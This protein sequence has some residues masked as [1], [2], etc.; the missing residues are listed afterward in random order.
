MKRRSPRLPE[1]T[2][3]VCGMLLALL[4]PIHMLLTGM[5]FTVSDPDS[6]LTLRICL[7]IVGLVMFITAICDLRA[8]YKT[9][10]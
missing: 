5:L 4:F 9:R 2:K 10:R 7:N 6:F 3:R 1:R 8:I